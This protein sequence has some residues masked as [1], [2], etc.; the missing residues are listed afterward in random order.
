MATEPPPL[1]NDSDDEEAPA[2][3]SVETAQASNLFDV[4]LTKEATPEPVSK[5]PLL[6]PP[7]LE[8]EST[9]DD[10]PLLEP[11]PKTKPQQASFFDDSDSE[12]PPKEKPVAE[13][14]IDE[15]PMDSFRA[16]TVDGEHD[17]KA[18]AVEEEEVIQCHIIEFFQV[19]FLRRR[20][21]KIPSMSKFV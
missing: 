14:V 19:L 5:D 10:K 3:P 9:R 2:D 6:Q 1:F 17:E 16:S 18:P 21:K 7:P 8:E 20:R 12:D 15:K 11:E 13:K 4:D